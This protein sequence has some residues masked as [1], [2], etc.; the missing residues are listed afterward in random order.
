MTTDTAMVER[1]VE[2]EAEMHLARILDGEVG[3]PIV[4]AD[5][6]AKLIDIKVKAAIDRALSHTQ[7]E[8]E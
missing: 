3:F 1:D 4:V 7:G 5:A 6:I 2:L 8:G